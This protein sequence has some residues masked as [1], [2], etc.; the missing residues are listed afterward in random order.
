M[1]SCTGFEPIKTGFSVDSGKSPM[2]NTYARLYGNSPKPGTT[3]YALDLG[4]GS[5]T[6]NG[7]RQR[8]LIL[9]NDRKVK[10]SD[11]DYVL[12]SSD[13]PEVDQYARD[14]NRPSARSSERVEATADDI[15]F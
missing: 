6:V 13:E 2:K 10:A 8:F 4:S 5:V 7:L 9:R 12:L 11:P 14:R 1:A 15:P 3:R